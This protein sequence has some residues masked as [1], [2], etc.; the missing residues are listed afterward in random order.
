[1]AR[2][3][4]SESWRIRHPAVA[5]QFYPAHP[6]E[7]A[8]QVRA[9]FRPLPVQAGVLGVVLPHAG[10]VY[11]GAVAGE[12]LSR[13]EVPARVVVL[14]PNHT[15]MGS[16]IAVYPGGS[17]EMPGGEFPVDEAMVARLLE[18]MPG[19]EA[20]PVA[21]R[22]EHSLEVQLP[23]L[24]QRRG[25]PPL[26]TPIVLSSL[27]AGICRTL[28]EALARAVQ[29]A[30]EPV[31][32][33]ASSDMNHYESQDVTRDKDEEALREVLALSPDNLLAVTARR[34]ISMCGVIP[35]AVMLHAALALGAEKA[36]LVRHATS[37]EVSG[38][39]GHVVG[40]A[41]VVVSR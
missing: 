1:M 38:D 20:D 36:E 13:V 12:T 41:G 10:Y 40:Y 5:G 22:R 23:F 31:L 18:E 28:G 17:W 7:L 3:R 24:Q 11:S 15:G 19:A 14:G 32:L 2:D 30:R 34:R 27:S 25:S 29:A 21:H 16:P 39:Y 37:G 26:I 6:D 9:T 4:Q 33:V 35:V 8:R